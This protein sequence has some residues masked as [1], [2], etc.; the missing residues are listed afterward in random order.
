MSAVIWER[1]ECSER[2]KEVLPICELD[3]YQ[4]IVFKGQELVL[5]AFFYL[6]R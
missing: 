5:N 2:V 6:N 4:K 1:S 3:V